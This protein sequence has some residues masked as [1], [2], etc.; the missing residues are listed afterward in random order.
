MTTATKYLHGQFNFEATII[1]G[2]MRWDSND[3]IPPTDVVDEAIS[4]GAPVDKLKCDRIRDAELAVFF[5]EYAKARSTRTPEQIAEENFE[6]RA[7]FGPGVE[8]VD[9]ITGEKHT[10]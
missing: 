7:A 10:T 3:Q 1:D 8:V 2:V 5:A 4:N 6:R 9:I